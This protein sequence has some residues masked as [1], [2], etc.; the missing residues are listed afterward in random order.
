LT[1]RNNIFFT[2]YVIVAAYPGRWIGRQG[3]IAW[4]PR[5]PGLTPTDFFLWGHL[6][7][8]VY[9]V[10]PGP[11]EDLAETLK[12][13]VTEVDANMLRRVSENGVR[14]TA[15]CLEIDVDLFE[16]LLEIQGA[17]GLII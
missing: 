5:S 14:H 4:P 6:K 17:D 2:V 10:P 8:H 11:I 3:P 15:V 1:F 12:A 7:E 16:H 9:A 13:A